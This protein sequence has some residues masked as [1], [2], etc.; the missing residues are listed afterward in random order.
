MNG[1]YDTTLGFFEDDNL[2]GFMYDSVGGLGFVGGY[3]SGE[4]Y[5]D[6]L[7]DLQ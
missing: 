4:C 1:V 2:L 6:L 5:D 7:T 3:G